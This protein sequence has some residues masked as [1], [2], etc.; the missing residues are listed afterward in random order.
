MTVPGL[1]RALLVLIGLAGPCLAGSPFGSPAWVRE[2]E[3]LR[4]AEDARQR[5]RKTGPLP[6]AGSVP[7]DSSRAVPAPET[8]APGLVEAIPAEAPELPIPSLVPSANPLSRMAFKDLGAFR[9]RP[10][11]APSR[12]RPD[13]PLA[14]T[15]PPPADIPASPPPEL[16]LV[17]IV[18]G[19]DRAVALV[20]RQEGGS[21]SLRVGDQVDSWRV[22]RIAPDRVVLREG[23]REQTYRLFALPHGSTPGAQLPAGAIVRVP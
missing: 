21:L 19:V 18:A 7:S 1:A 6:A 9:Q 2:Q 3:A 11:F 14:I 13:Q 10:L 22:D 5:A 23:E 12:R 20:S 4:Q 16:R 17:G 15:A 8:G